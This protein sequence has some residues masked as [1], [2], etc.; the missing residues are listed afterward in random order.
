MNPLLFV[1]NDGPFAKSDLKH[2]PSSDL[3]TTLCI[4][5]TGRRSVDYEVGVSLG[6]VLRL[7]TVDGRKVVVVHS[8]RPAPVK[9]GG[10][11]RDSCWRLVTQGRFVQKS[12]FD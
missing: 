12:G 1:W 2:F 11:P 4:S 6:L 8:V 7:T 5:S 3:R 10:V 9:K